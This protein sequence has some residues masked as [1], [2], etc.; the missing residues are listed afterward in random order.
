MI[1]SLEQFVALEWA[2][3]GVEDYS[4][5]RILRV[6]DAAGSV[7]TCVQGALTGVTVIYPLQPET[8]GK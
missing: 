5:F 8:A 3:L 1:L 4:D 7:F 6:R 2:I